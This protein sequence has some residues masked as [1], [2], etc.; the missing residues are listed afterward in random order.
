MDFPG[1]L[2]YTK[3]HE[4]VKVE[5]DVAVVGITD[6][7]QDALGDVVFVELPKIGANA[8]SHKSIAVVESVKSVSD[9]FAP[10]S[11]EIVEVNSK[12]EAAPEEINKSPYGA[13]WLFKIRVRDKGEMSNLMDAAKYK[14][15]IES[16]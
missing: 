13:G 1:E 4:W 2:K 14:N 6:Y 5:G 10:I 7:A 9:V 12:L 16:G 8:Q 11:G 3:D 15:L